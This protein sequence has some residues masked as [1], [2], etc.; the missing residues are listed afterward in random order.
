LENG[1]CRGGDRERRRDTPFPG[2]QLNASGTEHP[3][4]GGGTASRRVP[5]VWVGNVISNP[6]ANPN[7]FPT[8]PEIPTSD[9]A[10]L[11]QSFDLNA[12]VSDFKFPQTWVTDIAVDQQL[13]SGFLGTLE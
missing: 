13:G 10:T 8:A 6:G 12:M 9:D 4:R 1:D 11:A 5:F 3:A 2:G 7:L